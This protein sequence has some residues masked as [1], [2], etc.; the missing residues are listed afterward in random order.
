MQI[1]N[2]LI[3][4]KITEKALKGVSKSLY[5]FEVNPNSTK[6]QVKRAVEALFKVKVG[7]VETQIRKGKTRRFGRTRKI[8][9][10]PNIKLAYVHLKAG[11]IDIFP[12]S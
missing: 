12:Q 5:V 4:P 9:K 2:I 8:K 11:K 10:L 6:L 3:K 7:S 1:N